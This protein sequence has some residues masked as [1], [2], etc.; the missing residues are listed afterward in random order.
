MIHDKWAGLPSYCRG[1]RLDEVV[2]MPNH[3]HAIVFLDGDNQSHEDAHGSP[4]VRRANQSLPSLIRRFK[5][6][7]T[8]TA[9]QEARS[10][11]GSERIGSLWQRSYYDHVVRS[12]ESLLRIREYIC[13]NPQRWTLDRQ[14]PE[15]KESQ[16][17]PIET[18]REEW[19]V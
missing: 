18:R 13:S 10:H 15:F 11:G 8:T 12:D 1:V 9:I 2:V 4:Q 14:N 3:L 7:T 6:L 16:I 5:T 19:M 17:Q